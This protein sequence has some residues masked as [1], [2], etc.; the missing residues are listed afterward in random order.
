MIKFTAIIEKKLS[1][2]LHVTCIS[3]KNIHIISHPGKRASLKLIAYHLWKRVFA[4]RPNNIFPVKKRKSTGI[5]KATMIHSLHQTPVFTL[6]WYR[7]F[8]NFLYRLFKC[9]DFYVQF[10]PLAFSFRY[11]GLFCRNLYQ[12]FH[13]TLAI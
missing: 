10:H 6:Y 13:R 7:G 12:N 8:P 9:L 3:Q 4:P 1:L 2:S 11:Q 5:E